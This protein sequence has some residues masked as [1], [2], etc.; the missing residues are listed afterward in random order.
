MIVV[1]NC[2]IFEKLVRIAY[3]R[4]DQNRIEKI[5]ASELDVRLAVEMVKVIECNWL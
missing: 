2:C 3:N 5:K 1:Y 4:I